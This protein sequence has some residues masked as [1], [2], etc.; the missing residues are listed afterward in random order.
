MFSLY[1][2]ELTIPKMTCFH[3]S[4]NGCVFR[5]ASLIR[6]KLLVCWWHS[7]KTY[8]V[9]AEL[10][11]ILCDVLIWHETHVVQL[12]VESIKNIPLHVS[13]IFD[14]SIYF[15]IM[16]TPCLGPRRMHIKL[17]E[18]NIKR[19]EGVTNIQRLEIR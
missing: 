19:V 5:I 8:W 9:T 7:V 18:L 14:V 17:V 13:S 10:C 15:P 16:S 6:I 1:K 11:Y 3:V 12:R 4:R 2:Y